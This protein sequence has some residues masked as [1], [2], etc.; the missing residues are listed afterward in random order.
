MYILSLSEFIHSYLIHLLVVH[1]FLHALIIPEN[2]RI[3]VNELKIGH[4]IR[5]AS[6]VYKINIVCNLKVQYLMS[7]RFIRITYILCISKELEGF[8]S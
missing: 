6:R 7:M 5:V 2:S 3:C 4:F 1:S 8:P